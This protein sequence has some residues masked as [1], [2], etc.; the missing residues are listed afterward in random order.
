MTPAAETRSLCAGCRGCFVGRLLQFWS[1]GRR[2]PLERQ[3][4][5]K[6]RPAAR[7]VLDPD[8]PAMRLDDATTNRQAQSYPP[9]A[10]SRPGAV[11]FVEDAL[12]IPRWYARS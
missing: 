7:P 5:A 11:E 9:T 4:E 12:L 3:R 10:I 6:C 8:P 2:C 1:G